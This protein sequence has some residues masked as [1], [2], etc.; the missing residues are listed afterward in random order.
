[1]VFLLMVE[2]VDKGEPQGLGPDPGS[3]CILRHA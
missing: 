1:M 3:R 2:R